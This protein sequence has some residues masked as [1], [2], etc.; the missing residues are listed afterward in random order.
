[1]ILSFVLIDT[2]D[3]LMGIL[4]EASL[5][6]LYVLMD[7]RSVETVNVSIAGTDYI[8]LVD[9]DGHINKRQPNLMASL[10]AQKE[11]VGPAVAILPDDFAKLPFDQEKENATM[12]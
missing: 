3:L 7:V 5:T 1:M 12:Q 6:K 11:I 4:P 8:L 9:E 2:N 10:V